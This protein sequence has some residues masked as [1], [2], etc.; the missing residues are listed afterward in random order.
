MTLKDSYSDY[1]STYNNLKKIITEIITA[2][3]VTQE[4]LNEIDT[5]K[6]SYGINYTAVKS[7]IKDVEVNNTDNKI[8]QKIIESENKITNQENIINALQNDGKIELFFKDEETGEILLNANALQTRG[9]KLVNSDETIVLEIDSDNNIIF[10]Y[11]N[12]KDKPSINGTILEGNINIESSSGGTSI[13]DTDWIMLADYIASG[14]T[15]SSSLPSRFKKF[16]SLIHF[17]F[18]VT[19]VTAEN[20]VIAIIPEGYRPSRIMYFWGTMGASGGYPVRFTIDTE[21]TVKILGS[22]AFTTSYSSSSLLVLSGTYST[23]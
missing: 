9:F 18:R 12:L 21:G 23:T 16:G 17:D 14:I 1:S 3:E 6:E 22:K 4:Q 5:L 10:S 7:D 15:N 20:T 2:G 8:L 11:N 19:G 13:D